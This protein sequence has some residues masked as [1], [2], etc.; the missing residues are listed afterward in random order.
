[1][2]SFI[3]T[4]KNVICTGILWFKQGGL[5]FKSLKSEESW[6]EKRTQILRLLDKESNT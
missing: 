1:M 5:E 3:R 4:S 2:Y 6:D